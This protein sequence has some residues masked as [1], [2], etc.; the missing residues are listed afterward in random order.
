LVTPNCHQHTLSHMRTA[1]IKWNTGSQ[2][3]DSD[4]YVGSFTVKFHFLFITSH[5]T[6]TCTINTSPD[7]LELDTLSGEATIIYR[8]QRIHRTRMAVPREARARNHEVSGTYQPP[9][10]VFPLLTTGPCKT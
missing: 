5:T 3:H 2:P 10:C 6:A 1:Q 8:T 4:T 9:H 7:L